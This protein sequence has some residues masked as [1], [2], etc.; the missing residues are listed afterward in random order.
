[1]IYISRDE[2]EKILREN[3]LMKQALK[4]IR[5]TNLYEFELDYDYEENCVDNYW[6]FSFDE[7]I[8]QY[9]GWDV[10]LNV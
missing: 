8:E 7:F 1:M 2:L 4:D 6:P 3:R 10:D 5:E 9:D